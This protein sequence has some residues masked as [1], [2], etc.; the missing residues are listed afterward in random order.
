MFIIKYL[1]ST[2]ANESVIIHI[3][4][5]HEIGMSSTMHAKSF[6]NIEISSVQMMTCEHLHNVETL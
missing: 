1:C 3:K 2:S 5:T 4:P 6:D